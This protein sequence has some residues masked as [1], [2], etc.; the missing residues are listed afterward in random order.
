MWPPGWSCPLRRPAKRQ[1]SPGP[2]KPREREAPQGARGFRRKHPSG[3]TSATSC[4]RGIPAACPREPAAAAGERT[5]WPYPDGRRSARPGGRQAH[6]ERAAPR[7]FAAVCDSPPAWEHTAAG[8]ETGWEPAG[9]PGAAH[10]LDN[11][12]SAAAA[13]DN[14]A[15]PEEQGLKPAERRNGPAVS[16]ARRVAAR[17]LV[18]RPSARLVPQP[19]AQ[20]TQVDAQPAAQ[21]APPRA[22][23]VARPTPPAAPPLLHGPLRPRA[24]LRPPAAPRPLGRRGGA[25]LPWLAVRAIAPSPWSAHAKPRN[26]GTLRHAD[27]P[28]NRAL[29][30]LP[31][32]RSC[33]SAFC[34]LSFEPHRSFAAGIASFCSFCRRPAL[35]CPRTD[36]AHSNGRSSPQES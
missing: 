28:T 14:T 11:R 22:L 2:A 36:T 16:V 31:E 12:R 7:G 21:T 18:A 17:L 29:P 8:L 32:S 19:V 6:G 15:R 27:W 35:L 1:P 3:R 34:D 9:A 24:R 5:G 30:R 4:G 23:P 13:A 10:S 25:L 26:P 20:P 33:R